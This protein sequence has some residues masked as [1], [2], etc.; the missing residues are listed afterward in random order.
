MLAAIWLL[1]VVGGRV[2]SG[3]VLRTAGRVPFREALRFVRR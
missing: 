1:F 3:A 2:Y